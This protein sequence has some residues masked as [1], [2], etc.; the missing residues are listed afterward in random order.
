MLNDYWKNR[1]RKGEL[2]F[3]ILDYLKPEHRNVFDSLVETQINNSLSGYHIG[4]Y[5]IQ[6]S[7]KA[8][9]NGEVL[10]IYYKTASEK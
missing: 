1:I 5:Y 10:T 4:W 8:A 3:G 6:Y 7:F 9:V 2:D